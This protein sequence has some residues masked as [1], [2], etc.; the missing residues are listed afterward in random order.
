MGIASI[1]RIAGF[2]AFILGAAVLAT[3]LPDLIR[4]PSFP[5]GKSDTLGK[6][7]YRD[8]PAPRRDPRLSAIEEA[9]RL[10]RPE[11]RE[12]IRKALAATPEFERGRAS[13]TLGEMVEQAAKAEG[14]R[15]IEPLGWDAAEMKGGRWRLGFHYHRWPSLFLDT[16]W[17]YDAAS[18]RLRL[19]NSH[20]GPEFWMTVANLGESKRP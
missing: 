20:H 4:I 15:Q 9:A 19:L 11:G 2:L 10:T 3:L 14:L 16:E 8:S 18:E 12:V 17:E 13:K 6:A 7:A 1:L 5:S